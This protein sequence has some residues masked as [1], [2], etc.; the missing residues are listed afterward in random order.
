[1]QTVSR[2][3]GTVLRHNDKFHAVFNGLRFYAHNKALHESC[4]YDVILP[5]VNR[6]KAK[7]IRQE[8]ENIFKLGAMM[9]RASG[10]EVVSRD[11]KEY[12]EQRVNEW[13]NVRGLPTELIDPNN[14]YDSLL[15]IA[16]HYNVNGCIYYMSYYSQLPR[17]N[18]LDMFVAGIKKKFLK[19]LYFEKKPFDYFVVKGGENYSSNEWDVGIVANGRS[20]H[21]IG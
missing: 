21:M 8:Y 1:V 14:P 19:H 4:Y 2:K 3:G 10:V 18:T 11:I 6:A 15:K 12:A 16:V 20:V 9:I 13:P 5:K 7:T 17:S